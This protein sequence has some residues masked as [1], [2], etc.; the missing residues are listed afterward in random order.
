[1]VE[2]SVP[3]AAM[4]DAMLAWELNGAPIPLAHGGPL[5]IVVPGYS[6]VNSVKYVKRL[7]FT[8]EQ[9]L[10]AIQQTGY[11]MSPLG[12]K[13]KSSEPS[14]WE[15]SPKSWI[16]SPTAEGGTL[17][18][19]LVVVRG[20][21]FGGTAAAQKV[22]VSVDGAQTWR[23]ARLLGPDMGRYAWRAFALAVP[24]SGG[25]HTLM[26]R[27]WDARGMVQAE[28]RIENA[29]GYSNSSWRDHAVQVTVV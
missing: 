14:V 27:V 11:R 16:N 28:H 10:A 6:G 26:S 9:S 1:M 13:H 21:A 4:A 12:E 23:E 3:L 2:R 15:M 25:T 7:A 19:G 24:L 18:T 8:V 5:R 20:V 29:G 17:R 22:E